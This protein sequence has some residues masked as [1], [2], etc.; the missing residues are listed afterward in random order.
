M[1][2]FFRCCFVG[3]WF[4]CQ[5]FVFGFHGYDVSEDVKSLITRYFV[6]NI[7]LMKRNVRGTITL[8]VYQV[9]SDERQTL[10]KCGD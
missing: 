7:I 5:H 1:T 8:L 6:G 4:F 3:L 9:Y 2:C 10:N